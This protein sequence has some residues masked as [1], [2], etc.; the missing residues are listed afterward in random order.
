MRAATAIGIS[1]LTLSGVGCST[2]ASTLGFSPPIHKLIDSAE[3][4]RTSQPQAAALPSELNKQVLAAYNLE[5]GDTLAVE[6]AELESPVRLPG[7]QPVLPDG[8]IDLGKVGKP[9]VA[10]LT[11]TQAE[12]EVQKLVDRVYKGKADPDD[13]AKDRTLTIVTARLVGRESK[14]YYVLGEANAPRSFPLAGR[15]TVLDGIIAAGGI[16]RQ[17]DTEKIILSRP[18]QPEGCRIVL[19]I[20]YNN[21]VQ[22]GD[23]ST[24]YQLLPGDR[25]F[26]PS[27]SALDG[28]NFGHKK[29][30]QNCT[31]CNAPQAG[32]PPGTN[33]VACVAKAGPPNQMP[34]P[35]ATSGVMPTASVSTPEA[36]PSA[37]PMS[38]PAPVVGGAGY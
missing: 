5:P 2:I 4:I 20:C 8:T 27:K 21:I 6:P 7:S 25:I 23:T 14:V 16:T 12:A 17:A 22:L 31:P 37:M 38:L 18:T 9:V 33:P 32:C 29:N 35:T 26:I 30:K 13:P 3:A 1:I 36:M 34:L 11:V 19:P 24:N 15:E 28:L 10:G